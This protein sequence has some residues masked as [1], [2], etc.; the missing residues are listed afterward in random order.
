MSH[1]VTK[2]ELLELAN[3]LAEVALENEESLA[4][5]FNLIFANFDEDHAENIR[6][7]RLA[8]QNY[9]RALAEYGLTMY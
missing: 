7:I 5:A 9:K 4:Y 2:S 1:I 8:L 6:E 3:R